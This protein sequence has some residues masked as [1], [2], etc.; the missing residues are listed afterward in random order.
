MKRGG[1][2]CVYSG[3]KRWAVN[4][5]K[6]KSVTLEETVAANAAQLLI[7]AAEARQLATTVEPRIADSLLSH[8]S[9]LENGAIKWEQRLRWWKGLR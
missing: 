7:D 5:S 3:W 1:L 4:V 8:A 9:A 6:P 2:F